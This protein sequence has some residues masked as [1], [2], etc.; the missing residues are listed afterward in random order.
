MDAS[1]FLVDV[2]GDPSG[3]IAGVCWRPAEGVQ[4]ALWLA[5][6]APASKG[7]ASCYCTHPDPAKCATK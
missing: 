3:A 2:V 6:A 7:L 5:A 4:S 1:S